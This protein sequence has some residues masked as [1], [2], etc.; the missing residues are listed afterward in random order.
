MTGDC[1]AVCGGLRAV[2][3]G[4]VGVEGGG[5][6]GRGLN[7]RDVCAEVRSASAA[8]MC[9]FVSTAAWRVGRPTVRRAP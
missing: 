8:S 3:S 1:G 9:L 7:V 4:G 5:V 6:F 2:R